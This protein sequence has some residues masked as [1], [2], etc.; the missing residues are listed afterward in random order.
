[1]YI[2]RNRKLS[3]GV[4]YVLL[5]LGV[6]YD[7]SIF[8]SQTC[9]YGRKSFAC[10]YNGCSW[11]R[12]RHYREE[13]NNWF[14]HEVSFCWRHTEE[15]R[16]TRNRYF[17]CGCRIDEVLP[18]LLVL[19]VG[20]TV[21][22]IIAVTLCSVHSKLETLHRNN[23]PQ[24][25]PNGEHNDKGDSLFVMG[26]HHLSA[27]SISW[28]VRITERRFCGYQSTRHAIKSSH[29]HLVTQ[30]TRHFVNLSHAS[31]HTVSS[32]QVSVQQSHQMLDR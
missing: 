31:H 1:M 25:H 6:W 27:V 22:L 24:A 30:L 13:N 21:A 17:T 10:A 26:Y 16:C 23:R 32:S 20:V 12:Q 11:V 2:N 7:F 29:G 5:S 14:W 19:L 28:C 3:V 15:S 18:L 8:L 9:G 4:V